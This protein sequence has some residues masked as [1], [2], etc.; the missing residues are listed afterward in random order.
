MY[1]LVDILVCSTA[2]YF[3][4]VVLYF[5]EPVGQVKYKR[6]V[7]ILNNTTHQTTNKF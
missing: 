7:K 6:W 4:K 1:I 2:E 5:D 3:Y